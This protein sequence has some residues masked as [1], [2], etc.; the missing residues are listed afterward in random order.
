[1]RI[2]LARARPHGWR[3]AGQ[4]PHHKSNFTIDEDALPL[5]TS[6]FVQLVRDIL[7]I[8]AK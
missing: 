7:G 4:V 5:G 1:M 6:I 8:K 3:I 2:G